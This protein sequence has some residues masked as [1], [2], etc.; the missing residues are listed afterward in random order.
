M[1]IHKKIPGGLCK[2]PLWL[3]TKKY[4]I[5]FFVFVFFNLFS[6]SYLCLYVD[7]P[8]CPASVNYCLTAQLP[9]RAVHRV[10]V[11]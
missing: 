3:F 11:A 8:P 4:S 9:Q 7:F 5:Y 10:R 2:H 6:F 1:L